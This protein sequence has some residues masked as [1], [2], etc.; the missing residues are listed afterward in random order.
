[1]LANV[2]RRPS[3]WKAPLVVAVI[4]LFSIPV[5]PLLAAAQPR[6]PTLSSYESKA[7]S[8]PDHGFAALAA[9]DSVTLGSLEAETG[10]NLTVGA[11][12]GVLQRL[13]L[14]LNVREV[15]LDIGWE[16]FTAGS[17][18]Y[19]PWVDAWLSACDAMGVR[20][21]LFVDQLTTAGFDSPWIKSLIV[22]VPTAATYYGNG[23]RAGFVSLDNPEVARYVKNDLS[24]LYSYYGSH[25][26]WV[27]LGTGA[28]QNDP[29]YAAAESVPSVGYSNLSISAFINSPYYASDVN[30]T[31]FLLN[32]ELDELWAEYRNVQPALQLSTGVWMTST[33]YKVYG[34][35]AASSYVEMRF[36]IPAHTP[37]LQ[38]QWYGNKVGNPGD[39][40]AVFYGD[41]GGGLVSSRDL[42]AANATSVSFTTGTGWHAGIRVA[43]NFS[44]GWYWV[45][46]LSPTSDSSNYYNLYLKDYLINNAT[47]LAAQAAIG[48]GFQHGSTILWLS[49]GSGEDLAVYPYQQAEVGAPVQSF[50]ASRSFSFNS[51]FLFLS[52]RGYSRANAT[53]QISDVTEGNRLVATALLSMTSM[54]GLE[55]WVPFALNGTVTAI[56]GH[57]YSIAMQDPSYTWVTVARYVVTN[58]PSAGFQNQSQSLLFRLADVNWTQGFRSWGGMT[59]NGRDGVATG[60]MD[61][62]KFSP[63]TNETLRAVQILMAAN[64]GFTEN[65]TSG[66]ISA[67]IW[68]SAMDLST[69]GGPPLQELTLP[70]KAVPRNGLLDVTGFNYPVTAGRVYWIV[71]SANSSEKFTFGRLTNPYEFLVLTSS[72]G[73][74]NWYTPS[75]GPTEYAFTIT[76]SGETVGTFVSGTKTTTLTSDGFYAQSFVASSDTSVNS[77]YIGPL[78]AGPKLLVSINPTGA[79]GRPT[80][81]TLGF[82]VFDAGGITLSYGP[83]FIQF[84]SLAHLQKGEK[85][86]I[87]IHPLGG[88]YELNSLAFAASAPEVPTNSSAF[89]SNDGGLTWAPIG[90]STV[91][92]AEYLLGSPTI[93]TP[94]YDTRALYSDL[95]ANHGFSVSR[96]ALRGW[97]AYLETAEL[98]NFNSMVEWLSNMSGREFEFYGNAEANV[99]NQ[100]DLRAFVV[101]PVA[102]S[103]VSCSELM[104]Y[105]R[106]SIAA[107]DAQYSIASLS[108]LR[109]CGSEG[110]AAMAQELNY[111][112]HSG[113]HFGLSTSERMLVVGDGPNSNISRYLSNAFNVTSVDFLS[114]PSFWL[115][116]NIS[117]FKSIL[118]V[119]SSNGPF[120]DALVGALARYVATGGEL[121]TTN[122]AL[123]DLNFALAETPFEVSANTSSSLLQRFLAHTVYL[124]QAFQVSYGNSSFAA[125]SE[126]LTIT[127]RFSGTGRIVYL[128]FAS[129]PSAQVSN[130]FEVMIN[131]LSDQFGVRPPV[132]SR[133]SGTSTWAGTYSII[134][135]KGAPLLT[136]I[137]NPSVFSASFVLGLNASYFGISKASKLLQIPNLNVT[138]NSGPDVVINAVLPPQSLV[139]YLI[140][141][142]REPLISYSSGLVTGQFVYPNQAYFSIRGVENQLVLTAISTNRSA[143]QVI[144]NN[145]EILTQ[146]TSR[147]EL[148]N[149][150]S[151][152][153]FDGG[154]ETLLVKYRA[155]GSDSLR[156]VF[157]SSPGAIPGVFPWHSIEVLF[158]LFLA[159]ELVTLVILISRRKGEKSRT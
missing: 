134:G 81:S 145:A 111:L 15:L 107:Y 17:P 41:Q 33:P 9:D 157:Q 22:K 155:A 96:G 60:V 19:Q 104:N 97:N 147:A 65:Y 28:S 50:V 16:G 52:D 56:P 83:Q 152:W 7:V 27:G 92:I 132:W 36:Q 14:P 118:W 91:I 61:A 39:L 25:P 116:Y 32:G 11:F 131:V 72:D 149:S 139:A 113:G 77:V 1:M 48:P 79:D 115:D 129:L 141:P 12:E 20:N 124:N 62:V 59:T 43:G 128:G 67:A 78:V 158:V 154:T 3:V 37:E 110:G 87:V 58:P 49:D 127:L 75:E 42:A 125:Q 140:V 90:N 10:G 94:Q 55:N 112:V 119:S 108:A 18:P 76:L 121:A 30:G 71:F 137:Y 100:L 84:S 69:P 89:Y 98:S 21:V 151:G 29:Y 136:L 117:S 133:N 143:S 146:L 105:L 8:Y 26:S 148:Y 103:A 135:A 73:G 150:T 53:L 40:Q 68:G 47:G 109:R 6:S 64:E 156:Y 63:R 126:N 80:V 44:A 54:Q 57:E 159:A 2:S 122:R 85:Y 95:A 13:Y 101:L 5:E 82:G 120:S 45:K 35:G 31:G 142:A 88:T 74:T 99:V 93:R 66:T 144:L 38:L 46:F 102:D 130:D 86:W 138:T 24:I 153:Y 51:V 114:R 4:V 106:Y 23:T 70:A 123:A 34:N